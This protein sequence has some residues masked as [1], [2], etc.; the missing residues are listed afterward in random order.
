MPSLLFAKLRLELEKKEKEGKRGLVSSAVVFDSLSLSLSLSVG[1]VLC[2]ADS[3]LM[4]REQSRE[5]I[6][7]KPRVLANYEKK[8]LSLFLPLELFRSRILRLVLPGG[9]SPENRRRM[10]QGCIVFSR[11]YFSSFF[12][13]L[14][15][16]KILFPPPFL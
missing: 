10:V 16:L 4:R 11:D 5:A 9:F 12:L 13:P 2:S 14:W 3:Q 6:L 7:H 1:S 15:F 8:F